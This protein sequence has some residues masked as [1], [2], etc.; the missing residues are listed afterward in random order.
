MRCTDNRYAGQRQQF[1]LAMRL[2]GHEARTHIIARCT[3]FTQDRIRKL[4]SAYFRQPDGAPAVRRQRGKSPSNV[5]F[6]IRNATTQSEA[7]TLAWLFGLFGLMEVAETLEAR[8][9]GTRDELTFGERFCLLYETY[10]DLHADAC[11]SFEQAWNLFDA[12]TA[13]GEVVL[14]DCRR[15]GNIYIQDVLALDRAECPPCRLGARGSR[16]SRPG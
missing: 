5:A 14:A 16:G 6:F 12:L 1:D 4:Y 15:C 9:A 7:T 13:R 11:I 8:R 10:L 3:G 2:I